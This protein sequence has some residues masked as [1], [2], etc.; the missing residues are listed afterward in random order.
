MSYSGFKSLK[1]IFV[2]NGFLDHSQS[3]AGFQQT[4]KQVRPMPSML[5][6]HNH[7]ASCHGKGNPKS[8]VLSFRYGH[9]QWRFSLMIFEGNIGPHRIQLQKQGCQ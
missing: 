7:P 9:M 3:Q 6:V 5:Q 2:A 1:S 8:S 4:P